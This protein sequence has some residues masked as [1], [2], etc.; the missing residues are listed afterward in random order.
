[1]TTTPPPRAI[2]H[3]PPTPLH[4]ARFDN[5]QHP[6]TRK[7]TR[8][9]SRQSQRAI[10]TPPPAS[11]PYSSRSRFVAEIYS[12]PSSTHTSPQSR[13]TKRR[14]GNPI[15]DSPQPNSELSPGSS[16]GMDPVLNPNDPLLP[17]Q[18][19]LN[20][21][22]GMLPTP[23]KTPRKQDL[24]KATELQSAARVLFP[25]R[26]DK[27]EDAM[28]KKGRR[29][30]KNVG[31]SLDSSGE[32]QESTSA[33]QIF[34]DS[35]DKVPE[36]DLGEDNPFI[37]KPQ[38]TISPEP[39]KTSGRR[40]RK[41][42]V[43]SNPQIEEAFNHEEGMVYVFRGKKMFRRFTPD[44]EHPNLSS[45]ETEI[46]GST[47]PRLRP[48]T[49]SSVKPRLLFPTEKQRRE[50]ELAEEE[51]LTDIEDARPVE[52]KG[53]KPITPIKQSFAAPATP[54]TTGHA[55][56]SA[57]KQAAIRDGETS[58]LGPSG[59]ETLIEGLPS[60]SGERRP[61]KKTSPFDKWQ[62]TKSGSSIGHGKGK[63]RAVE[64]MDGA[65]EEVG[66]KRTRANRAT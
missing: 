62:R 57:T 29:G 49:R 17:E 59:L 2:V 20:P 32:D 21:T 64:Q 40:G 8:Q 23:A 4:G 24:R 6:A 7:S 27:V 45:E 66:S 18:G 25:T 14:R 44:P 50:R 42:E 36:L 51:A 65:E 34:T 46:E 43:K 56:R 63:K 10:H 31:F 60:S 3:T 19:S 38:T 39:T 33:I 13:A 11:A 41:K 9:A 47:S 54:P 22:V 48:L 30:R 12:P 61:R 15:E 37:E 52:K 53:Q 28:P 5:N 26:L 55:T 1:M 16:F 35:K 58:P